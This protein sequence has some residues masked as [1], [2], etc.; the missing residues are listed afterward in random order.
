MQNTFDNSQITTYIKCPM[1]YYLQYVKGLKKNT[2]DDTNAS[3][4]FGESVH[5]FLEIHFNRYMNVS[6]ED[7]IEKYQEPEDLPQY[8]KKSLTFFCKTYLEKYSTTDKA[9]DCLEVEKPCELDLDGFKFIVKKDGVIKY[10]DNIYGLEN[11]TTKSISF[12]Y[13]DKYFLNSQISAQCYS[14]FNDYKQCSGILLNVG[15]IKYLKR[16]PT[17]DYDGVLPE[18]DGYIACK[19]NRDFVNRN[20]SELADWKQ[21]AIGWIKKIQQSKKDDDWLKAC[22]SWGGIICSSCQYKELCKVSVGTCLDESIL[23]VLYETVNPYQYL[24][25]KE[26]E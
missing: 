1:A 2:I 21:T 17:G 19:F 3:M 11:K 25:T 9:F 20:L 4:N 16:K 14:T 5:K 12:N 6:F 13:F 8:S 7:I 10:N 23:D 15:E 22:G 24:E 26:G 18:G